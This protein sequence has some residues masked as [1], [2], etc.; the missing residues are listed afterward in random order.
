MGHRPFIYLAY[1]T[2]AYWCPQTGLACHLVQVW[3]QP[4]IVA[5]SSQATLIGPFSGYCRR[6][7]GTTQLPEPF[8]E[9][10][11]TCRAQ[12]YDCL[13]S[14]V[15][16]LAGACQATELAGPFSGSDQH[17]RGQWVP[18][19][20]LRCG[21]RSHVARMQVSTGEWHADD[22]GLVLL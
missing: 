3:L 13:T 6:L 9:S 18:R 17:V 12:T 11:Q 21:T 10:C 1:L 20:E 14:H 19:P 8:P 22:S 16:P 5:G 2:L 4:C 7:I 15:C